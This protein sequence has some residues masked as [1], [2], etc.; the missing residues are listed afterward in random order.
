MSKILRHNNTDFGHT[1][2]ARFVHPN[3]WFPNRVVDEWNGSGMH[4]VSAESIVIFKRRLKKFMDKDDRWNE[5]ALF[6]QELPPAS[7]S[8]GFLQLPSFS[9]AFI[10]IREM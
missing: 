2:L 3:N 6:L 4:I 8:G 1:N 5:A 7:L 9:D 10:F